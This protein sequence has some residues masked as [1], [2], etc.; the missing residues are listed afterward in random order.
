MIFPNIWKNRKCSKPPIRYP[1]TVSAPKQRAVRKVATIARDTD[2]IA[3]FHAR[4][5]RSRPR[6]PRLRVEAE[7]KLSMQQSQAVPKTSYKLPPWLKDSGIMCWQ[8]QN[9][10]MYLP[11]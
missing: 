11:A 2:V 7:Q 5:Q 4:N 9:A 6:T 3:S 10:K 8:L 1:L